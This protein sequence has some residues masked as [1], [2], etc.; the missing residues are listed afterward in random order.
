MLL[1]IFI[2]I[3]LY[4]SRDVDASVQW[5]FSASKM[6]VRVHTSPYESKFILNCSVSQVPQLYQTHQIQLI[7][8]LV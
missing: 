1:L 3:F 2:F 8:S 7:R 5:K 4:V 6:L